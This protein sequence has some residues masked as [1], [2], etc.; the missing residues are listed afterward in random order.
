MRIKDCFQDSLPKQRFQE[1]GVNA[2]LFISD[3][4]GAI[5]PTCDTKVLICYLTLA[6]KSPL[7]TAN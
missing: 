3:I 5:K 2:T 6:G 4:N 1:N 7:D